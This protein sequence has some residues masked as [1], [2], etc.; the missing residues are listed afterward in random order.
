MRGVGNTIQALAE[1]IQKG[2]DDEP[3][4]LESA[5]SKPSPVQTDGALAGGAAISFE[6]GPGVRGLQRIDGASGDETP[7]LRRNTSWPRQE[8]V[9][10]PLNSGN[11]PLIWR[12]PGGTISRDILHIQIQRGGILAF[13][14]YD[15]LRPGCISFGPQIESTFIESLMADRILVRTVSDSDKRTTKAL[16]GT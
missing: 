15:I 7:I 1:P 9:I 11:T 8:F 10:V 3:E 13:A 4:S 16:P 6:G 12:G 2:V 14:A 5:Q